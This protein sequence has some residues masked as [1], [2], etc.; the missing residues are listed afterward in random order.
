MACITITVADLPD[1]MVAGAYS[2]T[3]TNVYVGDSFTASQ[4]VNNTGGTSGTATVLFD[5]GGVQQTKTAVI[6][7]GG[8][9][10]LTATYTAST[11]GS[12]SVCSTLQPSEEPPVSPVAAF[13]RTPVYV[14]EGQVTYFT[15][16]SSGYPTSWLWNFGDGVTS[17]EQDPSHTYTDGSGTWFTVTLTVT[18]AMGSNTRTWVDCIC[19]IPW[20]AP[21]PSFTVA[22]VS[23]TSP[24]AVTITDTSQAYSGTTLKHQWYLEGSG[25]GWGTLSAITSGS[26]HLHIRNIGCT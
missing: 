23:G 1:N 16:T 19:S 21:I 20:N 11:E 3:P 12:V 9:A 18:N 7:A 10:T 22:P 13:T 8:T 6:P 17:T 15:D 26:S 2:V 5:A 24:L 4:V 25:S 14:R